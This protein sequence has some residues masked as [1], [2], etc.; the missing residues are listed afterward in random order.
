MKYRT[1]PSAIEATQWFKDGDH[2]EVRYFGRIYKALCRYCGQTA[3]H[4][5]IDTKRG[6]QVVCPGDFV[7][8]G[9]TGGFFLC[10]PDIFAA[11]YEAVEVNGEDLTVQPVRCVDK[12]TSPSCV[13][14]LHESCTG[15]GCHDELGDHSCVCECHTRRARGR[16]LSS[17]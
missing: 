14:G 3:L 2:P 15:L 17:Y 13:N 11:N 1:K 6:Y 7:I 4:G 8:T 12:P 5:L 10:K 9:F 16:W